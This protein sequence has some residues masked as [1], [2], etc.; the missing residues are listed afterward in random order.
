MRFSWKFKMRRAL[1][2]FRGW[3]RNW[4]EPLTWFSILIECTGGCHSRRSI[5]MNMQLRANERYINR[6]LQSHRFIYSVWK[7]SWQ[8]TCSIFSSSNSKM[9]TSLNVALVTFIQYMAE[10]CEIIICAF[11][12]WKCL[13]NC[14]N[15]LKFRRYFFQTL[16][17]I[18]RMY[19]HSLY[20]SCGDR[21]EAQEP[22]TS[23]TQSN[24]STICCL[25]SLL[26]NIKWLKQ[27]RKKNFTMDDNL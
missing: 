20:P 5:K 16:K 23:S 26:N 21:I 14:S 1:V 22:S 27:K 17:L 11:I 4:K 2:W 8:L 6:R 10:S 12:L 7:V 24:L 18:S 3:V 13:K 9:V 25:I 19:T 15:I